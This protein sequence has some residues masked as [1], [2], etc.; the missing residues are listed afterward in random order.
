MTRVTASLPSELGAAL[1]RSARENERSLA[2]EVRLALREHLKA[3][4]S[5][6]SRG[7]RDELVVTTMAAGSSVQREQT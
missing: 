3:F 7:A 2:A 1:E 6:G 4:P 5:V